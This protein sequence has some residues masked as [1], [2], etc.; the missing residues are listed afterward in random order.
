MIR[1]LTARHTEK[2]APFIAG[3]WAIFGHRNIA[4]PRRVRRALQ[5]HPTAAEG[6]LQG[7]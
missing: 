4:G 5:R 7:P 6:R 2:G 3:A 1:W